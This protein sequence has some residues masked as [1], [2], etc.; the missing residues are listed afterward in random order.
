MLMHPTRDVYVKVFLNNKKLQQ[1]LDKLYNAPAFNILTRLSS[2]ITQ[3][4]LI[5]LKF[6]TMRSLR[7][8]GNGV[9]H[10]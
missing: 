8:M 4:E 2:V 9:D 10:Q 7:A 1:R 6:M 5:V 3:S